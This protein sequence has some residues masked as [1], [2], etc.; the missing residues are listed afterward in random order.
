MTRVMLAINQ[1]LPRAAALYAAKLSVW[2]GEVRYSFAEIYGRV[3]RLA[4]ALTGRGIGRGDRVGILDVNSHRYLEAYY[5]C[6]HLGAVLVPL[7]A[8]LSPR[9]LDYVLNDAGARAMLV[10]APFFDVFEAARPKL[11][12]VETVLTWGG[13]PPVKASDYEDALSG[14]DPVAS[15]AEVA[16]DEIAQ[17]Y[18]TSGTTGEPKGVCL[19]FGNMIVSAL[20]AV[21]GL[22]LTYSDRWLHA[23]P[24]FHLVDAWS[25]W[26]F[27]LMGAPQVCVAFA[28]EVYLKV[29]DGA[30]PTA[31]GLPPTLINMVANH[32]K[33][34]RYDHSSIRLIMYGG[35]PTPLGILKTAMANIPTTYVQAYGITETS[36]ITTLMRPEDFNPNGTPE[37]VAITASAGRPVPNID[38]SVVDD[39][40]RRVPT[41]TRGEVAVAGPRVMKEYW[42]RPDK[43]AEVMIGRRY[44]TGDIGYLDESGRLYIV[45][46][47]KDMIITGGENVYPAEVESVLSTHPAVLEVAVIGVPDERWGEAVK[48]IVVPRE[49]AQADAAMLIAHC[50]GQI[51]NYK[52]PKSVDFRFEP[53]PKTGPGKV[54]KRLL[55][56]PYWTGRGTKI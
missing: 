3:Q 12:S 55:R 8:R 46:R 15:P 16:S 41:G 23:A 50:Q 22:G 48:A 38:L 17:I 47:K 45:D 52:V 54:A 2:D 31:T 6:A 30:R 10:A 19:T 53:L 43:T 42:R 25:I 9:E 51:A 4:G 27:P 44:H 56:D 7:N 13:A 33:F 5:A 32:P 34:D 20:D 35:S 26:A 21:I 24:V 18:Y 11:D 49:G 39:D 14:S 1:L 37:Q 40:G 36:G 29:V 28:P